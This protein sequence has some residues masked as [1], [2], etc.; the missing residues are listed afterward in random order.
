M[1]DFSNVRLKEL[2]THYIGN[3]S[4]EEHCR[5]SDATTIV[6]ELSEPFLLDYFIKRLKVDELNRFRHSVE[7]DM[8]EVYRKVKEGFDKLGEDWI[9]ISRDLGQMLFDGT[10]HPNIKSG[11][12]NVAYFEDI[13][14]EDEL[15]DG[16]GIFKSEVEL[17]FIKMVDN[18]SD[19][20]YRISHDYG[21][22][23]GGL[24]KGF[25][26][27]NTEAADGYV[28]MLFDGNKGQE[29]ARFWKD[30]F[31]GLAPLENA[32]FQTT[33]L[34]KLTKQ[35]VSEE[36]PGNFNVGKADQIDLL[37]RSADY[38]KNV[39]AYDNQEF[40]NEVFEDDNVKSAFKGYQ[41]EYADI[42]EMD[43]PDK[44]E[45]SNRAVKRH[46]KV[47]KSVLKLDK[48][49]HIYIHGDRSK[50]EKG[51]ED[52]GRKYYKVYYDEET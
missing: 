6:D 48:N 23:V 5:F 42:V 34:M 2:V 24:D 16:I 20:K 26:V 40:V 43:I 12:L 14:I 7:L 37:N 52:D 39:E 36:L 30:D 32:Y 27:L 9:K 28:C 25:L 35:F 19:V 44:F 4:R 33:E 38:F 22:D 51:F 31:L 41:K 3:A 15:V 13:L 21:Y 1:I 8:N 11:E 17:P 49:F 18:K 50:I 29:E 47:F 46:S 45:L 10:N